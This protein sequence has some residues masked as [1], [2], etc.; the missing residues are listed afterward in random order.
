ML[1]FNPKL[2]NAKG[3][4]GYTILHHDEKGGDEALNVKDYLT[5]QGLKET[6]IALY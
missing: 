1:T 5:S 4:H 2:L 6:R 3:P